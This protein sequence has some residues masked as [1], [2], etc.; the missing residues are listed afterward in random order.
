M[1]RKVFSVW[2]ICI[3]ALFLCACA[4]SEEP[5]TPAITSKPKVIIVDPATPTPTLTLEEGHAPDN[6]EDTQ[7]SE[8]PVITPEASATPKPTN[9]PVPTATTAPT[10]TPKPSKAPTVTPK[11][12]QAESRPYEKG[13]LTDTEFKSKWIGMKFAFGDGIELTSQEELDETMRLMEEAVT[14]KEIKG[15]LD[16]ENLGLVYEMSLVWQDKGLIMQVMVER[17]ADKSATEADYVAAMRE[18]MSLL[19]ESGFTYTVD[20]K[21]YT[22]T[23]AGKEFAN[24]G[25]TT[26]YGEDISLHQENY[27]RKQDDRII[28]I[29][30][31][32][33]SEE[34]MQDLLK[35]FKAY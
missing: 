7:P 2:T 9:T 30:I 16:Y 22:E 26:Y 20:D 6:A 25:Y 8:T 24:F 12:T 21:N 27:I 18:E 13:V 5:V 19:E 35:R 14:G 33:E 1:K 29:S 11:P 17:M 4:T 28:L 32:G 15:A 31:M 10:A 34:G 23:I 3:T